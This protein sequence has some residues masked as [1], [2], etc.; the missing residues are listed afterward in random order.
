MSPGHTTV[1]LGRDTG[2]VRQDTGLWRFA[3]PVYQRG[4]N[5]LRFTRRCS[6]G[7]FA[8][9]FQCWEIHLV[10][11]SGHDSF[12]P[13]FGAPNRP[14][15]IATCGLVSS[16]F[17]AAGR[18]YTGKALTG[19]ITLQRLIHAI[20]TYI[21]PVPRPWLLVGNGGELQSGG[22]CSVEPTAEF[23]AISRVSLSASQDERLELSPPYNYTRK[24]VFLRDYEKETAYRDKQ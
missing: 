16:S 18:S 9:T 1:V 5:A 2:V 23:I 19:V 14:S 11:I 8:R 15:A 21:I 7:R 6:C 3:G 13:A 12:A 17:S 24:G 20:Q 22:I 4:I 10:C